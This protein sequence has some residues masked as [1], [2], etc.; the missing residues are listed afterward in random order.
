MKNSIIVKLEIDGKM[1]KKVLVLAGMPSS[2]KS[3]LAEGISEALGGAA[4]LKF[5]DYFEFL[6]GWPKDMRKWIDEGAEVNDWKNAQM[7]DDLK[8]LL[9]GK[10]IVYP[11]TGKTVQPRSFIIMEDPSG[12]ERREIM[13]YI[14]YLLYI[15]IPNEI[16]LMRSLERW[17]YSEMVKEDGSKVKVREEQPAK[18][19]E[20][21]MKYLRMF[22]EYSRDL[23][24]VV[25]ERVKRDADVILDG[26]KPTK[27]L[28]K[29]VLEF[30]EENNKELEMEGTL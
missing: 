7:V 14:D 11:I 19:L 28:V 18:L 13:D 21:M 8:K 24:V 17:L 16:S 22:V 25:C 9:K 10:T 15:D 20:H 3:T 5:D 4:V 29:E 27:E 2:G 30:L 26:L 1:K 6:Q 23:Y 12:R